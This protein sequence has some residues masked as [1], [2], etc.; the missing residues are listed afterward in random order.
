[1]LDYDNLADEYARHREVHPGVLRDLISTANLG[2]SSRVLEIGCGTAN[3][4]VLLHA[5]T[6]CESTGVDPSE[7]MLAIACERPMPARFVQGRAE[8]L[9]LSDGAFDLVFSVD[10][11][12]HV[13][14]RER[15]LREAHRV[16][17]AGGHVCMVTD[18]EEIIRRRQPMATY[19]PE[20]VDVDLA[21]YPRMDDLR[22]MMTAAGFTGIH[23]VTVESASTLD[24]IRVYRE[25]GFSALHL[26]SREAFE[27]G[28]QRMEE[29]LRARPI[30]CVARYVLV[31]G[32]K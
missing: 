2:P 5:A 4:L 17:V 30:R 10:V 23:D 9:P 21:R 7:K 25:K 1:M 28:I 27:R 24:D 12:H 18:S 32:T 15:Y 22:R 13:E 14:P 26:I 16:L 6:G 31:W 20:T 19:F 3:Y 11:I 8:R 29:D